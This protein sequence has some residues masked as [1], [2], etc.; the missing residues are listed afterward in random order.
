MVDHLRGTRRVLDVGCG[1]GQVARQLAAVG[2][3]VIG[4]DPSG[5]QVA[6]G[7]ALV[8]AVRG[9]RASA[10]QL[11]VADRSVDA[12]L[13]CLVVRARRRP[14]RGGARDRAGT[15]PRRPPLA[16]RRPPAA[17]GAR[18]RLDRRQ[19]PRRALLADRRVPPRARRRRRG[20]AGRGVRVRPSPGVRLREHAGVV[21]AARRAHGRAR[22]SGQAPRRAAGAIPR[23]T[24]SRGSSSST[25]GWSQA[26]VRPA[27]GASWSKGHEGA[28]ASNESNPSGKY[29]PTTMF[30]WSP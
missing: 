19:D 7:R 28:T 12:V 4:V 8:A 27:G 15:R 24:P 16:P 9:T 25:P 6:L 5:P 17:P 29:V 18:E 22:A 21:R 14:P 10:E 13:A 2:V 1:E 11:P 30:S 23:P 26:E 20:R 3:D